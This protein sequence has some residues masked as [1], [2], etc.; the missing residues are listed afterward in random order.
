[1][2]WLLSREEREQH[3]IQL[4]KE[5]KSV[6]EIAKLVHMSFRDIGAITHKV[7]SEV[8]GERGGLDEDD[9]IESKS[10]NFVRVKTP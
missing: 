2:A 9:D 1:M 4:Y 6:R 7:K 3:V 5:N 10:K 8:E